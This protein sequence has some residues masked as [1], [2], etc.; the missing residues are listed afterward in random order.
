MA[1]GARIL[2]EAILAVEKS[3]A[4]EVRLAKEEARIAE[5]KA[6][7]AEEARIAEEKAK[8]AE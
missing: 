5:E 1:V 3:I 2:K 7:L 6:K 8:L 4:E